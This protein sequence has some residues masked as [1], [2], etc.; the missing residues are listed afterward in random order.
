MKTRKGKTSRYVVDDVDLADVESGLQRLEGQIDLENDGLAVRSSDFGGHH[1]LGFVDF[2][3]VLK[4]FDAG[5]NADTV[6]R[7]KDHYR[8]TWTNIVDPDAAY[9]KWLQDEPYYRS[10]RAARERG[11]QR[12]KPS[13]MFDAALDELRKAEGDR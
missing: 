7:F 3:A 1:R 10:R 8:K 13:S 6:A 9:R 2:H 12:N 5:K 4:E 11:S